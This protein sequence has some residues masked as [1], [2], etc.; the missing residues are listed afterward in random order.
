MSSFLEL[1]IFLTKTSNSSVSNNRG[2]VDSVNHRPGDHR[3]GVI[4]G[5]HNHGCG[6]VSGGGVNSLGVL[7]L[8]II[9]HIGDEPIVAIGAVVDVLNS[10]V[11]KGDRV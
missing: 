9:G 5:S 8:A 7:G 1:F 6:L 3:G 11:G 10:A 4:G 2:G